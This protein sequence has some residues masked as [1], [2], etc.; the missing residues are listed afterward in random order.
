MAP[1]IANFVVKQLFVTVGSSSGT[2]LPLQ[3]LKI[4]DQRSTVRECMASRLAKQNMAAASLLSDYFCAA[5]RNFI[6]FITN[7]LELSRIAPALQLEPA[8][9]HY[10]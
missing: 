8:T 9:L 4:M 5:E 3:D 1:K 7:D 10:S 6:Y 2:I